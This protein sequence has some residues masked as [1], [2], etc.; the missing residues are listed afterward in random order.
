MKIGAE[1]VCTFLNMH[2]IQR[3]GFML[4][5][6]RTCW[7]LNPGDV[8]DDIEVLDTS[9]GCPVATLEGLINGMLSTT[10]YRIKAVNI[11]DKIQFITEKNDEEMPTP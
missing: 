4:A 6:L 3:P 8:P 2:M 9:S 1:D 10:G 7:Q 11:E 5:A